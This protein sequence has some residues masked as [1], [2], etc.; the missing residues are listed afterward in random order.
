MNRQET[1]TADVFVLGKRE[2]AKR[3][4]ELVQDDQHRVWDEYSPYGIETEAQERYLY[5]LAARLCRDGLML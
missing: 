4:I 3:S 1:G 5:D 2:H